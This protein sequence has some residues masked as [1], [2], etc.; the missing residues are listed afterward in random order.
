LLIGSRTGCFAKPSA[1]TR[2]KVKGIKI[3]KA[4]LFIRHARVPS[5]GIQVADGRSTPAELLDSR[6]QRAG[7]PAPTA[8]AV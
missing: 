3:K 6:Q 4:L 1:G 7:T 8:G 5:S 2:L